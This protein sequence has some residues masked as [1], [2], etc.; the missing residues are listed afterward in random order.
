KIDA[1]YQKNPS[2]KLTGVCIV[3]SA[4]LCFFSCRVNTD[5]FTV[6][7]NTF[8]FY[9][10][11]NFGEQC[12]ISATTYVHARID[13]CTALAV[14]DASAIDELTIGTLGAKSFRF[15]ITAILCT[16]GTFFLSKKLQIQTQHFTAPPYHS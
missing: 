1:L 9:N 2:Q 14:N 4:S 15:R 5:F 12:I 8:I 11:V 6:A 13:L 7:A 3:C 10:T 16:S